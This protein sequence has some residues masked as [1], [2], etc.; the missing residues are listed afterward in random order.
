MTLVGAI[1]ALVAWFVLT[2]LVPTG[3]GLV[4]LLLAAGVLLFIRW[5]AL[6]TPKLPAAAK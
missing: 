4:H 1:V 6:N 2:F 3:I 5:Y